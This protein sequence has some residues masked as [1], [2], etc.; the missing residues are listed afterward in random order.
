MLNPMRDDENQRPPVVI[1]GLLS[2]Y[3]LKSDPGSHSMAL[4]PPPSPLVQF[5]PCIFVA[6]RLQPFFPSSTRVALYSNILVCPGLFPGIFPAKREAGGPQADGSKYSFG[7]PH[8]P[9]DA[10]EGNISTIRY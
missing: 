9:Y 6:R 1:F 3:L 7:S 8:F 4:L 2:L 5:G 10:V